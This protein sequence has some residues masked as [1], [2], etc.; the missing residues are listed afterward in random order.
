MSDVNPDD[1]LYFNGINGATGDYAF[2]PLTTHDLARTA[3][4]SDDDGSPATICR[5]A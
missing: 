4:R 1:L 2:P 3:L 5:A